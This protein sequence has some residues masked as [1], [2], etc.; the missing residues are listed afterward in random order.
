LSN[1]DII[2]K[3][4]PGKALLKLTEAGTLLGMSKG[5]CYN[6]KCRGEF[7]VPVFYMDKKPMVRVLDLAHYLDRGEVV[8]TPVGPFDEVHK[9][10][11]VGRPTKVEQMR[12]ARLAGLA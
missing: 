10:K 7:P 11:K 8:K 9:P 6:K 2:T 12:K 4:F 3:Q 5:T 1:L